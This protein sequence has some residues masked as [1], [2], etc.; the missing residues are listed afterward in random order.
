MTTNRRNTNLVRWRAPPGDWAKANMD[1]AFD[2]DTGRGAI[3]VVIRNNRGKLIKAG[4]STVEAWAIMQD[5][6]KL[7]KDLPHKG[8][9][10][11][12]RSG[13][14]LAHAVAKRTA[15]GMLPPNWSMNPPAEIKQIITQESF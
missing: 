6:H 11:I 5:I 10:W 3:S 13:N 15:E 2:K 4:D 8:M 14:R 12:P 1:A 9:T 7:F